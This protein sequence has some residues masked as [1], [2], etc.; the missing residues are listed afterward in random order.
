M[1]QAMKCSNPH[2]RDRHA[3]KFFH[4]L[5]HFGSGLAGKGDGNDLLGMIH[6]GQQAQEALNEQ[7]GLA[8]A[9]AERSVAVENLAQARLARKLRR[10]F[11]A[12]LDGAAPVAAVAPA[13]T[14]S[15]PVPPLAV[16]APPVPAVPATPSMPFSAM[17][18]ARRP[19]SG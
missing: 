4:P 17:A 6:G 14:E 15:P 19:W 13:P 10:G 16:G 7:A 1:C 11:P 3:L 8:G 5:A 18:S 12:S 2:A 9:R